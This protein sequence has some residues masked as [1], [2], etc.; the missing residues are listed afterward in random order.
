MSVSGEITAGLRDGELIPNV[1]SSSI[2]IRLA[3]ICTVT[4]LVILYFDLSLPLGVAGGVPYV[5]LVLLGNWSKNQK[6]II[7]LAIAGSVLTAVGFY[8]S[9]K[10]G[11]LWV[12]LTNRGLAIFAI[13]V[14]AILLIHRVR[15]DLQL[16]NSHAKLEDRVLERTRMLSDEI[17]ERK[18][19]EEKL[20]K[21]R[22]Y[23][24]LRVEERTRS[25]RQ[26]VVERNYIEKSLREE[27]AR[28]RAVFDSALDG[29]LTIND[30]GC[31]DTANP[32]AEKIFGYGHEMI[33]GKP[34]SA[35]V[36]SKGEVNCWELF[37]DFDKDNLE[38]TGRRQEMVGIKKDGSEIPIEIVISQLELDGKQR[39]VGI[40][41][42]ITDRKAAQEALS[43]SET[44]FRDFTETASDW[45]WETGPDSR[46]SH[47]SDH[48]YESLDIEPSDIIG[49]TPNQFFD[50]SANKG[51]LDLKPRN[52]PGKKYEDQELA[53][54]KGYIVEFIRDDGDVHFLS[55]N[56]KPVYNRSGDF[57]GYRGTGTDISGLV[58]AESAADNQKRR[59]EKFLDVTE[60][61]IVGLDWHGNIETVNS[62]T[63]DLLGYAE[64]EL[65]GRN[66]FDVAIPESER[67]PVGAVFSSLMKGELKN[68][69]HYENAI[70]TKS[71]EEIFISWHNVLQTDQS[72]KIIG[73]LS[74]GQNITG[75]KMA[76]LE[77]KE[78]KEQAEEASQAK[79]E[80][81]S[82][83]SH[84]LRT[85]MNAILGFG[86]LLQHNPSE[87]LSIKQMDYTTQILKSGD[88]LLELIDQVLDLAKI[89]SGTISLTAEIVEPHQV[90][91]ECIDMLSGRAAKEN[92]EIICLEPKFD[93]PRLAID[94]GRFRQ[95]LLNLLS[96]AVKYNR[97]G[98][99]IQITLAPQDETYLRIVV[100]DTG[101]GIP[102]DKAKDLFEPFSR[103]GRESGEIEGTGIGL[104]ITRQLIELL[105]GRI[106]FESKE[107]IGSTFWVDF[108]ITA[109]DYDAEIALAQKSEDHLLSGQLNEDG[110]PNTILYI[111]DNTANLNLMKEVIRK[112][113]YFK[114]LAAHNAEIGLEIA[115]QKQP[116]LVL[117]DINLPGMNGIEALKSMQNDELTMDIPVIALTAEAMPQDIER[118]KAAG[119][120]DY[121]TKPIN[122]SKVLN[123]IED[124]LS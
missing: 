13:W 69:E 36:S 26:E 62:K 1:S 43:E 82:S 45:V 83:M 111:E 19:I 29:I 99:S 70:L 94:K 12:V 124:V 10:G 15:V 41:R 48:F 84:E 46:F 123:V 68:V 77:L 79:S 72:G 44:K 4:A 58:R 32:E 86:Q 38:L 53:S 76:E 74:S 11:I 14:T 27:E 51:L 33:V 112:L 64:D 85:P 75:R 66:W 8:A 2:S 107:N 116:D 35:L 109:L 49:K 50:S 101:F 120:K 92:V 24:E 96:N 61:I 117:M 63:A 54:F 3:I 78:A 5:A 113:P 37:V 67:E 95:V 93:L 47:F 110:I 16:I 87:P 56:G 22:D 100:K 39:F 108:P 6:F 20:S 89:E 28:H 121:I 9:P 40:L 80:F 122:V 71:G 34:F 104:S 17:K 60:A 118:G 25:L 103:L 18:S 52:D 59:A 97:P 91:D 115:K 42:N 102:K 114:M 106:G 55:I 119:F 73:T 105:N 7:V 90:V 65:I 81:L 21:A 98:G 31:I 30:K 23:L 88:H 57:A